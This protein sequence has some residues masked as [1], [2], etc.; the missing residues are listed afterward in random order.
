M[1]FPDQWIGSVTNLL[2]GIFTRSAEKPDLSL[3][4]WKEKP[5]R[6]RSVFLW[7]LENI[8]LGQLEKIKEQL[9]Y[10]PSKAFAI[11]RLALGERKRHRLFREGI[12][13][14]DGHRFIKKDSDTKLKEVMKIFSLYEEVIIVS[15]DSDFAYMIRALLKQKK[16]VYSIS[17]NGTNNR[18]LMNL[19][20]DNSH[21]V[22]RRIAAA[23]LESPKKMTRKEIVR[24][25]RR[26]RGR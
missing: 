3:Y 11:T 22:M 5:I 4:F 15:S 2:H 24:K 12:E 10:T 23:P 13:L 16:K 17:F 9:P 20:L 19:P 25:R 18:L 7:D 6:P 21:L 1:I 8:A 14:L 26:R